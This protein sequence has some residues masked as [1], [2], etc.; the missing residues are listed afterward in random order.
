MGT[1]ELLTCCGLYGG[2]CARYRGYTAFRRAASIL[3]E[4]C[5]AHGF[6]HWMPEAATEFDYMEFRKG[7]DF[8][9]RDDTWFVCNNCCKGGGGG[10]PGCVRECCQEHGVDVCFECGEFPC[11]RVADNEDMLRRAEEY[12]RLGREEWLRRAQ[13][14]ADRGHE[15]HTGNRYRIEVEVG[16][17]DAGPPG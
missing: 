6:V 4:V 1:Q 10:P 17:P 16:P 11:A 9:A 12:R 15:L 3:A 5:D 2:Q 13:D 8:F 7:L 14:L